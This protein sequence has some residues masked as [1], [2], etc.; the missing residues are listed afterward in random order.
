MMRRISTSDS[1]GQRAALAD[2]RPPALVPRG[3]GFIS[4]ITLRSVIGHR[5][6][7]VA[8]IVFG[9]AQVNVFAPAC[10]RHLGLNM[11]SDA[12]G[13]RAWMAVSILP[14]LGAMGRAQSPDATVSGGSAS[15]GSRASFSPPVE[16]LRSMFDYQPIADVSEQ[17]SDFLAAN[18]AL[19]G[20]VRPASLSAAVARQNLRAL[21]QGEL[22]LAFLKAV[23]AAPQLKSVES[24]NGA[25]LAYFATGHGAKALACLLVA[26]DRAPQ[27]PS[28]LLNLA[29]AALAFRQANE[30]VALIAEA[31]K[32]GPLPAGTWVVS[33]ALR[34]DYLK[35][36]ACMLRG[37]Y[38]QARPLLV[39]VVEAAPALKEGSLTLALVDAQ[40]GENPR[41]PY[42][43]GVW[44]GRVRLVVKDAKEPTTEE[45]IDKLPDPFQEGDRIAPAMADLYDVTSG[46]AGHLRVLRLPSSPDDLR[47]FVKV[48]HPLLKK[49][50]EEA[51]GFR[52]TMTQ[53][54]DRFQK[55][56]LPKLYKQRMQ[57]LYQRAD[58]CEDS[59]PAGVR[60]VRERRFRA[61][62]YF[63]NLK[64]VRDATMAEQLALTVENATAQRSR[65]ALDQ[66]LEAKTKAAIAALSPLLRSY[67]RAIDDQFFI[68]SSYL[69]GMLSHIGP[70]DLRTALIAEGEFIR[71]SRQ[72]EQMGAINELVVMA[73]VLKPADARDVEDGE[74]GEGESCSDEDAKWT[75]SIDIKIVEVELS[76]KSVSF[77]VDAPLGPP[78]VSMSA[79]VGFDISGSVTAFVGPK[80]SAAG[81][82]SA[83][84]GLYITANGKGV[85]GFGGKVEAKATTGVGPITV[86]RQVGEQ[87]VSF[88][89]GPDQGEPPGGLPVF[90]SE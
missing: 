37:E 31:E 79:E 56:P 21:F 26:S 83:K 3:Q 50:N 78:L 64:K 55:A 12:A 43:Q 70:S 2:V 82:G 88:F 38:K 19:P 66:L 42:L 65:E 53:A 25:A 60:A 75:V 90:D 27:D 16:D 54:Q 40:L 62:Q 18:R 86:N 51:T 4:G 35:G 28:A 76:C 71:L 9:L 57:Q 72:L 77:E 80:A 49:D 34:A 41:K 11:K 7:L 59:G 30:A 47:E 29:A 58:R 36:Y 46:R 63:A 24:A 67:L 39:R 23:Q 10:A 17:L 87:T 14:L 69:Y 6:W 33:G 45:E 68:E 13:L 44:R 84:G 8:R 52:E 61:R 32:F 89:P 74:A 20:S 22:N 81:V 73:T 15:G 5:L 85:Q 1:P 48:C